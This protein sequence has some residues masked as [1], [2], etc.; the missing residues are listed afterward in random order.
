MKYIINPL[1]KITT[2]TLIALIFSST[3]SYAAQGDL[4]TS[5]GTGGVTTTI[6]GTDHRANAVAVQPDGKIVAGGYSFDGTSFDFMVVRY[7]ANG[8]PDLSFGSN[9]IVTTHIGLTDCCADRAEELA[10]QPDGKILVFG[11]NSNQSGNFM[12]IRYNPDGSL[13]TSFG[14]TVVVSGGEG[15]PEITEGTGIV[16]IDIQDVDEGGASSLDEP[17]GMALQADGKIVMTGLTRRSKDQIAVARV[18]SDGSLDTSFDSDGVRRWGLNPANLSKD[19][20][21]AIAIQPDGKIIVTG[22]TYSSSCT[23]TA[24]D[25]NPFIVRLNSDGSSDTSFNNSA[26][27]AADPVN[28]RNSDDVKDLVIQPDG[29]FLIGG[30]TRTA[31]N[32]LN[33]DYMMIR[34][35]TD[36]SLDN[37]F[38]VNG[39]VLTDIDSRD[40]GHS[41]IVLPDGRILLAGTN[42]SSVIIS[43]Y[44]SDGVLDTSFGRSGNGQSIITELLWIEGIAL[45]PDGDI[46]ISGAGVVDT[47]GI[48]PFAVARLKG[49]PL[50]LEPTAIEFSDETDVNS[51]SEVL[52]EMVTVAG[53]GAGLTVPVSISSGNEIG[54][55]GV[56][57]S[58]FAYTKNGDQ[59]NVRHTSG[60][61]A[62][63]TVNATVTLGGLHAPD[64]IALILGD[65]VSD[66]FS[67]T[68]F[69]DP[70]PVPDD[71]PALD[72]DSDGIANDADNAPDTFN[73]DQS[74]IDNDGVGDTTDSC[75]SDETN[76]CDPEGSAAEYISTTGGIVATPDGSISI[77]LPNGA[78][79][80]D[81]SMSITESGSDFE[82]TTNL[83]DATAIF[84]ATIG[85]EGTTFDVPITIVFSWIDDNDDGLVDGTGTDESS[86]QVVKD[87]I[88]I[89]TNCNVNPTCDVNANTFSVDV[90]S[91]S[92]FALGSLDSNIDTSS[93]DN[94]SGSGHFRIEGGATSPLSLILLI[95]L[96]LF[97]KRR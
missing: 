85:P 3:F 59:L 42:G 69:E 74:D 65:T 83:G 68:V 25:F 17:H 82:L 48:S 96:G 50:D 63:D 16:S 97:R 38:G 49:S 21:K 36:G 13:D 87:G 32:S 56:Y 6:F 62:G 37:N 77:T 30:F 84:S 9:G 4:D 26:I 27:G 46:L 79:S 88:V 44:A 75:P 45:Q 39:V 28:I 95:M 81:T 33:S 43:R 93:G 57:S 61:S 92:N 71:E 11:G 55:N 20:G 54:V 47:D 12:L 7:L 10:I 86:L 78:L 5:F 60:A 8:D 76:S 64:N 52:S 53:L 22:E 90:S 31:K 94:S 34:W 41:L 1:L 18:N 73:P 23:G 35:N 15:T 14:D 29:K 2:T 51:N 66:T 72:D 19:F 67:S 70:P 91:L 58:T 89:T 80:T 24:C 40:Q